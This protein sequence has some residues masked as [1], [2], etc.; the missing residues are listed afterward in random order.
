MEVT[1]AMVKELREK[2][3]AGMMD[4]KKALD[5]AKGDMNGAV[6]CLRKSGAAK[7]EKKAATRTAK[8]GLIFSCIDGKVGALVEVLCET[9]FVAKN[10][11]FNAYGNE[12]AKRV[13]AMAGRD[14]DLAADVIAV[15]KTNI[16]DLIN[17]IGEKIEI[18]RVLRWEAQDERQV[19]FYN[20]HLKSKIVVMIEMA[21]EGAKGNDIC[22]HIAA[23]SPQYIIPS[24]VPADVIARE[25]DIAAAQ[26]VGK[27]ANMVEKI[28]EGKIAKWY[29]DVC[30]LKMPWILDDKTCL[31]KLA[32]KLT[33][34]RML[35]WTVGEGV[36]AIVAD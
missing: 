22:M 4:C 7:A 26:V 18:R 29:G 5:E 15:E 9:D 36:V 19:V 17:A 30:L 2:T 14:G 23:Y 3:G 32:P 25:K 12:L 34:R 35:R 24:D 6:D 16:I 20:H 13:A 28:V 10:D 1:A 27:P 21:G 11:R 33:V 8:E 31:E